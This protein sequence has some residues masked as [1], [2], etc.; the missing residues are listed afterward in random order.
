MVTSSF[1]DCGSALVIFNLALMAQAINLNHE[2]EFIAKEV[3]DE[4][5]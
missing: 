3:D 5:L 1:Q 2:L 4:A